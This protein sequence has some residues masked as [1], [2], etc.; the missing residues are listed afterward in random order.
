MVMTQPHLVRQMAEDLTNFSSEFKVFMYGSSNKQVD[1]PGVTR[2]STQLTRDHFL[3]N[4]RDT[5]N[6]HSI[7][8]VSYATAHSR[9]GP[10]ACRNYLV[11]QK[12][13]LE[14]AQKQIFAMPVSREDPLWRAPLSTT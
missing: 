11:E 6:M 4:E 14:T 3:F 7:I 1:P 9:N 12:V 10:S 8:V 2:I 13:P 5:C